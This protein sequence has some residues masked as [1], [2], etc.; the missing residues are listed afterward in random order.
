MEAHDVLYRRAG[1]D[2]VRELTHVMAAF[3][4]AVGGRA[5]SSVYRVLVRDAAAGRRVTCVVA[6]AAGRIVG[7]ALAI[8]D[9]D[10]YWQSLLWRHPF[11]AAPLL[12]GAKR[13]RAARR[14]TATASGGSESAMSPVRLW[15]DSS[16]RIAKVM[17]IGVAE[18][19]R[20]QGIGQGLYA[21][22]CSELRARGVVRLDASIAHDNIASIELHK[23][24][25][26]RIAG[27]GDGI[28]ASL[29]LSMEA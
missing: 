18:D 25:G 8:A 2:D 29:D 19:H 20:G 3:Q 16:P 12:L 26:W 15:S 4:F 28:Y 13:R 21:S 22:L 27:T 7:F 24:S 5:T 11:T 10:R 1:R 17:F 6:L 9:R 23:T 14:R